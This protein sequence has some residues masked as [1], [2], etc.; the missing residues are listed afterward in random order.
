[1]LKI[2]FNCYLLLHTQGLALNFSHSF[3]CE[4]SSK[5]KMKIFTVNLCCYEIMPSW[6]RK[7]RKGKA[8]K[9]FSRFFRPMNKNR[10]LSVGNLFYPCLFLQTNTRHKSLWHNKI[11]RLRPLRVCV[12][13]ECVCVHTRIC[14]YESVVVPAFLYVLRRRRFKNES[15][16]RVVG[17]RNVLRA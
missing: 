13:F 16:T 9:T 8:Q 4:P 3:L 15:E 14:V 17:G 11:F 2:T 5:K 1:M 10:F 12:R 7:E 6:H